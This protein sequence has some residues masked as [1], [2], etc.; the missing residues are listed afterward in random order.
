MNLTKL[1][2]MSNIPTLKVATHY[3]LD[4]KDLVGSFP[5]NVSDLARCKTQYVELPGWTEDLSTCTSFD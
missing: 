5:A 1:D 2:V 3:T 4:G